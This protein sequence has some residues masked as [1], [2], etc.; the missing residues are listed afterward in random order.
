MGQV[1]PHNVVHDNFTFQTN[2]IESI[3]TNREQHIYLA[4]A[5]EP[6]YR[7]LES[8]Q[9]TLQAETTRLVQL[10]DHD[11]LEALDLPELAK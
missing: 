4:E 10:Y 8:V 11:K 3:P 1:S 6:A 2:S 7:F 9:V 5:A